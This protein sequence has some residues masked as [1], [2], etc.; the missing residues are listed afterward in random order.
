M[1]DLEGSPSDKVIMSNE[2]LRKPGSGRSGRKLRLAYFVTHPIQY[3]AP[4]LRRVAQETDID[5]KVYFSS[6]LSVRGHVDPG[7]GV[8]VKWDVPLL[9]GYQFEFLPRLRD[10]DRLSF[11]RPLNWG[12]YKRLRD[13]HYDAVWV[14]GYATATALQ[15]M[16]AARWLGIPVLIRSDSTLFDR[17][18]S[19]P[20]TITKALFFRILRTC[21]SAVLS[22]GDANS[23]Y[24]RHYLGEEVPIFPL[25]YSVDNDFFLQ[26]CREVSV[27]R[28]DFRRELHL[29]PGRSVILYA[30]KLQTRKRCGDLLEAFLRLSAERTIEPLPYLLIVGDGEERAV[31]QERAKS[32]RPGDVRFL[33]F[34]NQTALPRFFDLCDVFVLASVDEPWG[35]VVNEVMNA[36]RAVIVSSE[37]GC[38]KNLVEDGVNGCVVRARDVD[39][40]AN[41]LKRI[42]ADPQR[43]REMGLKSLE[44]I[45]DFSFE[46]NVSGLRSALE[47]VVPA[48]T[49][50]RQS[51]HLQYVAD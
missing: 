48:F 36:G 28:E 2:S 7:F 18:R 16:L 50:V 26:R 32:A 3:Q 5:L 29:E 39:G 19:R 46:Q 35:L 41:S 9:A 45:Q 12:I 23:A 15:A 44:K 25:Y 27:T 51:P 22:V 24:W 21:I 43:S 38:Q 14:H 1:K 10:S 40:L 37:V 31:L 30:S 6:D 42:L 11:F 8:A 34:Q 49:A 47:A 4:L 13:G 20:K 33:G 17:S